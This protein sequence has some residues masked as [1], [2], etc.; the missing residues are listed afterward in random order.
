MEFDYEGCVGGSGD[1]FRNVG[2]VATFPIIVKKAFVF[3]RIVVGKRRQL[4][5]IVAVERIV[6]C[7]KTAL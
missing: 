7:K 6:A 5:S 3:F 2:D 1:R 4:L